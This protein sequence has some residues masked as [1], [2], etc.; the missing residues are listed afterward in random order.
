[1]KGKL[2]KEREQYVIRLNNGTLVEV[3]RDVYLAWYQSLRKERYQKEQSRKHGVCSLNELEEKGDFFNRFANGGEGAEE[4]ALQNIFR[5]EVHR[6]VCS[7]P[8]E[9]AKLI[10]LL[11]FLE[12]SVT[13]TAKILGCCQKTVRNRRKRILKELYHKMQEQEI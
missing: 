9:D 6:V 3:T 5:D 8:A 4:T 12:I 2:P 1:M 11:Y 13:D 7:L 10:I